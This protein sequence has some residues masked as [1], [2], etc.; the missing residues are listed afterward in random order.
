M[1]DWQGPARIDSRISADHLRRHFTEVAV[2]PDVVEEGE[3]TR[4]IPAA[5]LMPL[6]DRDGDLSVLLTRRTEHLHDH[7]GQIAFPG[8]R[9]EP[10]DQSPIMTALRETEEE[11]GLARKHVEVLG[12]LPRY[13]TG[14]GFEVTPVVAL[15]SPP[16]ELT[17]DP[18]EVAE[19]FEVPFDFL[20]DP[21]NHRRHRLEIRGS[22]R[23][24]WAM[25]FGDY[26]IWGA[27]A[28]M[29]VSL[30]RFLGSRQEVNTP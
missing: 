28:G 3:P 18:F 20:L 30:Y 23:E 7:P 13:H 5:V 1:T 24:F 27:T 8:G 12:E 25:P 19:V 6:V 22:M 10:S 26:F 2:G 17:R 9:R 16:F 15:V 29:L 11:I 14:T 21:A 4:R